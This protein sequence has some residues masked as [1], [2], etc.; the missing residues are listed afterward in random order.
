M[1]KGSAGTTLP[2]VG[3]R[4]RVGQ[5]WRITYPLI[6]ASL[7][8][9]V[10]AVVDT[11]I[12]GQYS[13][14][15]LATI[16]LVLPIFIFANALLVPWGTA[17]Q[18]L[19]ARWNGQ[20]NHIRINR[21]LDTGLVF[22]VLIGLSATGVMLLAA[23]YVIRLVTGGDPLPDSVTVLRVLLV[24]LP[25][26]AFT[27]HYRG[28]FGGLGETKIAMRVALLVNVT[29]IPLDYVLV[30][31]FDLG[32]V[33]SAIGTLVATVLGAAYIGAFGRRRLGASYEF[34]RRAN[35]RHPREVLRPLWRVGWPDVSFAAAAYGGDV[36]LVTLVAVLGDVSLAAYRL[37]V[38][39]FT[40]LWVVVFSASSGISIL[41]GQRLGAG[42]RPGADAFRN[43]GTALMASL[44]VLVALPPVLF[45]SAFFGL[46]TPDAAVVAEAS[47]AVGVLVGIVPAMILSMSLAGV[48]R[49]GGDTKSLLYV[50]VAAQLLCAVPTA[51]FCVTV[52]DLGL[53]GIYLGLLVGWLTRALLTVLRHRTGRW[54]HALDGHG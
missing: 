30:F 44:A 15:A 4:H 26:T 19:V 48:L 52:L 41:A 14:Q 10:L 13:T 12:L 5:S 18:V 9:V 38:T 17:T 21:L 29:N 24:G 28:L 34:W 3:L 1:M 22:V 33:G 42:D 35:L 37:L 6:V 20:G 51:W 47:S 25:F 31:G 2:A 49:A 53:A 32:A 43:S 45:P 50:G 16:G 7:T 23:P 39:T 40:I 46:F 36:L 11:V 27:T 8:T 54:A